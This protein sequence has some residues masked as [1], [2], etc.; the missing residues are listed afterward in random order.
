MASLDELPLSTSAYIAD[1]QH[2][3]LPQHGAYLL[4]LM[5]MWRAG[6]WIDDDDKKLAVICKVSVPK[7]RK[8]APEVRA[9]LLHHEGKLSQKRLLA[10]AEIALKR[11]TQNRLN[12]STG[13]KAK[14]LKNHDRDLANGSDSVDRDAEPPLIPC[15]PDSVDSKEVRKKGHALPVTWQPMPQERDYG[16]SIGLSNAQIDRAA[17]K[18]RRWAVTN[19]HR[20][21]A[22]KTNWDL[23]F[24]NW[25]DGEVSGR[26]GQSQRPS[27]G[28]T[29]FDIATGNRR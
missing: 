18:M 21:V 28:P 7:W 6:G 3:T 8:L 26:F 12:G 23:T 2:L 29:M 1:T 11:V 19:E 24:R 25:L 20:Q 14:A 16:L 10:E 17:E 13:G 22:R 4:I 27:S 9:L 5:T 15:P